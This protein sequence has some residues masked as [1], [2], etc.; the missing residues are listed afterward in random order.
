MPSW[1][2]FGRP[3]IHLGSGGLVFSLNPLPYPVLL[4]LAVIFIFLGLQWYVSLESAVEAAEESTVKWL[5]S[6]E[7][8][9]W[10]SSLSSLWDRR[11]RRDYL[12]AAEG[13]GGS[14]WGGRC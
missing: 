1:L 7:S 8:W 9:G 12:G 2:G 5:S 4:I 3:N 10:C 13:R 6:F 14:P 11:R